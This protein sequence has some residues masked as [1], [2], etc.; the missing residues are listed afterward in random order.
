MRD[1]FCGP[2]PVDKFI[3]TFMRTETVHEL[4]EGY[5]DAFKDKATG[6]IGF[7]GR[8]IAAVNEADICP[9]LVLVNT[10][11]K[12]DLNRKPDISV[13]NAS[14]VPELGASFKQME[15][16]IECKP[17]AEDP[18]VDLNTDAK[19]GKGHSFQH[20]ADKAI[21]NTGQII[22]Y[23][24]VI[25]QSQPRCFVFS[26]LLLQNYA[27]F[28]RWDR[29]GA[30]VTERFDWRTNIVHLARFFWQYNYLS[31]EQR[32]HD[33]TVSRPTVEEIEMTKVELDKRAKILARLRGEDEV[34]PPKRYAS[35]DTFRKFLVVNK[36][37]Q[38]EHFLVASQA[39]YL[40][41][42]PTGR[43][44]G[45]YEAFDLST[46]KLV[47]LK[48]SWRYVAD[49][50]HREGETYEILA[51]AQVPHIPH[52]LYSGDVRNQATRTHEFAHIRKGSEVKEIEKHRHYRIVLKEIGRPLSDFNSTF[53]LCSVIM[54]AI[55]AHQKAYNA[56][57]FH[58]DISGGNILIT[59]EGTGLLIDWDLATNLSDDG[60][61]TQSALNSMTGTWQYI[62]ADLLR[63][64]KI[65]EFRDDLES[66]LHVLLYYSIRY[67]KHD[68]SL[69]DEVSGAVYRHFDSA[70]RDRALQ[71]RGGQGKKDFFNYAPPTELSYATISKFLHPAHATLIN[72]LR[73][74][75]IPIYVKIEPDFETLFPSKHDALKQLVSSEKYLQIYKKQLG[76]DGWPTNNRSCD[77]LDFWL[78]PSVMPV[79]LRAFEL[80]ATEKRKSDEAGLSTE[81]SKSRRR[82][83]ERGVVTSK[84]S[85]SKHQKA[86][87]GAHH[88]EESSKSQTT[89]SEDPDGKDSRAGEGSE[90]GSRRIGTLAVTVASELEG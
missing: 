27:R 80:R 39:Q 75:F 73:R 25:F 42:S 83:T 22:S 29:A 5:V 89:E 76:E 40:G 6:G 34:N 2:M 59:D 54:H 36:K 24:N 82:R 71:T 17:L 50:V 51:Q 28:I 10:T 30:V 61:V 8:F 56:K 88:G 78:L 11:F 57:V 14:N 41:R 77:M 85:G 65:H 15:V 20:M 69:Y 72:D 26:V 16:P 1:E 21:Y 62:S 18:F 67:V 90:R 23:T 7:E 84:G 47:F 64:N 45:G 81:G 68:A 48:D 74:L 58:R 66:F 33:I 4:P 53:E 70:F 3:D 44:T 12:K 19:L 32:G 13:Y 46:K 86:E 35:D 52:V 55:E 60:E 79:P 31:D 9:N 37:D 87:I 63:M 38:S 49:G 43:A